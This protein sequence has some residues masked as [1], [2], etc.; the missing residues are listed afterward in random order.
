MSKLNKL[1]I[2]G[3]GG[4]GGPGAMMAKRLD[5]SLDVT[6][7]REEENFITRCAIPYVISGDATLEASIKDDGM[8]HAAG[9]KLVD[10]RVTEIDRNTKTVR[11]ADGNLY[12][13]DKLVL[14]TGG[15]SAVPPIPGVDLEGVFTVRT[16]RDTINIQRWME[17]VKNAAVIGAGAIG[18]EMATSIAKKGI[19]ITLV[20]ALDHVLPRNLD[21]D[22]SEE[23]ERY[24]TEKGISLRLKQEVTGILGERKV[25]GIELSSGE[26]IDSDMVILSV[27]VRPNT[28]LAEAAGLEIG[29]Y[30]VKVNKYLQTSDPDIYAAGDLIEYESMITG[31][32]I[33]GQIRSNAVIGGRVIVKN[34]LGY[35]IE[36]PKLL[37]GFATKLFDKSVASVGI[38]E[39]AAKEEGIDV[40]V[41]KR[42][43]RSKYSMIEGGKPYTLKLIFDRDTKKVIGGQMIADSESPIRYIDVIALAIRCGLT[44][45]DL[46]T[47]RSASQPELSPEASAEAISMAAEDAFGMLYPLDKI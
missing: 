15:V 33:L 2:V 36:F 9:I 37:N 22:M 8:F 29:K 5:P 24:L 16:G 17:K 14:A 44:I 42:T 45:P 41:A 39:K 25:E 11:T 1:V 20:E 23:I 46:M 19:N 43:S 30:G 18:L 34:A 7:I 27:G 12:P 10:A 26:K 21:S 35:K 32:P 47:F 28:E 38:T 13:Y 40:A 3:C 31:K 4:V 6:L